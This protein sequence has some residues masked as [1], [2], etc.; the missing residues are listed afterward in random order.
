MKVTF[1]GTSATFPTKERNHTAVLLRYGAESL[2]FDCG[3]GTQRQIRIA[4]ESPMKITKIFVTHWHGDHVLG[5][6]GLIQSCSMGNRSAE[7]DV[8]G[9]KETKKRLEYALKS[10]AFVPTFKINV[11]EVY[12]Q[13]VKAI[14]SGEGYK[15]FAVNG[16]HKI[17][18][19]SFAFEED[20]RFRINKDFVDKNKLQGNPA[21]NK[22]QKGEDIAVN[23]KKIKAKDVT[24]QVKGK[25]VTYVMDTTP[26][27]EIVEL[28]SDSDVLICESTFMN[29][30]KD[31]AADGHMTAKMAGKLAKD[32][33]VKQL[34]ITHFSQRY[35]DSKELVDEAKN[36]FQNTIAA[37]D[38]LSLTV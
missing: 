26:T 1:L 35:K 13:K 7:L 20:S 29:D 6:S 9:P 32:A 25:K 11:K 28:A 15:V 19:L 14:C 8:Y 27:K 16:V 5:L 23:G 33:K 38:F 30:L 10:C 17:P 36:K 21:L 2:L 31:S 18:C 3:E 34:V 24:Y 4:E 22:L 37:K 12:A